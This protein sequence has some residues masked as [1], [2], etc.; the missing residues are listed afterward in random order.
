MSD[1][2]SV[3]SRIGRWLR[4]SSADNAM[5]TP[6]S[7]L[8]PVQPTRSLF[9]RPW[10][11]RD[12]KMAAIQRGVDALSDLMN[13]VRQNL[14]DQGRRQDQLIGYLRDLPEVLRSLPES[15]RAQVEAL[16]TLAEHMSQQSV[17]QERLAEVME[18]MGEAHSGQKKILESLDQRM[19]TL[20]AH[21]EAI[22]DHLRSVGSAM[23]N[24]SRHSE[25]STQVLQQIR[26][27]FQVRGDELERIL[28]RQNTR[29]TTILSIAIVLAVASLTGVCV[30]GYALLS[31]P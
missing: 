31:K 15:Q 17:Q 16:R 29:F 3:L 14:E 13:S 5:L 2:V 19:D 9:L 1:Q 10:A 23:Q 20:G 12:A 18:K 6:A 7:D 21:D 27:N 11:K 8:E 4:G 25:S 26:D 28:H 24:V 30:I 22:S